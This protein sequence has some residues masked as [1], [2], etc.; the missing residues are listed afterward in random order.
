VVALTAA[1]SAVAATSRSND[2]TPYK[3]M[4]V[5]GINSIANNFPEYPAGAQAAIPAINKLG[6]IG[7]HPLEVTACNSQF[8]PTV[9]A[10][11]GQQAVQGGFNDVI[12][13]NNFQAS[14][15]AVTG[16]AGIPHIATEVSSSPD[17]RLPNTFAGVSAGTSTGADA[18]YYAIKSGGCKT[19]LIMTTDAALGYS[20]AAVVRNAIQKA[21]GK[22][23]GTLA[24][25]VGILDF[26]ALA[27]KTVAAN[28]DCVSIILGGPSLAAFSQAVV[29]LG[30]HPKFVTSLGTVT[31]DNFSNIAYNAEGW[32][33]GNPL[34]PYNIKT[35]LTNAYNAAL[36]S[37]PTNQVK[38]QA[39]AG[40]LAMWELYY[41]AKTVKGPVTNAS[42]TAA[43]KKANNNHPINVF[44]YKWTPGQRGPVAFPNT[45]NG[46]NYICTVK[47]GQY[48]FLNATPLDAWKVLGIAR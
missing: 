10:Q 18:A 31:P 14:T 9:S 8:S 44:G 36:A 17:Y 12:E 24:A 4:V 37:D 1:A 48:A 11:C 27:Q 13:I 29:Q 42:M 2:A 3:V 25:P 16:P 38:Q 28:P 43:A 39:M 41:L 23:L 40:W 15:A 30:A 7:G 22:Y 47:N 20:L 21:G 46:L 26:A 6:G 45:P 32:I 35:P 33:L 19:D 34:P 5:T